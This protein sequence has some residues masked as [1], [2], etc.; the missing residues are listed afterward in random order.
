MHGKRLT[1]EELKRKAT[2]D[3]KAYAAQENA[4]KVIAGS[5][6]IMVG[7]DQIYFVRTDA[8]DIEVYLCTS[9]IDTCVGIALYGR[10]AAENM[11]CLTHIS[12]NQIPHLKSIIKEIHDKFYAVS[13]SKI[14]VYYHPTP[15]M[16]SS[17]KESTLSELGEQFRVRIELMPLIAPQ[18]EDVYLKLS[19]GQTGC[20]KAKPPGQMALARLMEGSSPRKTFADHVS[21]R[22]AHVSDFEG[23]FLVGDHTFEYIHRASGGGF[24][25]SPHPIS[26]DTARSIRK[27][28]DHRELLTLTAESMPEVVGTLRYEPRLP[29][30]IS[31]VRVR[32]EAY[33]I[34]DGRFILIP[35]RPAAVTPSLRAASPIRTHATTPVVSAQ[36]SLGLS[37]DHV[38]TETVAPIR[39]PSPIVTP[40]RGAARDLYRTVKTIS[41]TAHADLSVVGPSKPRE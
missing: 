20:Y 29:A 15:T 39:P 35:M 41:I 38:V 16:E 14:V 34:K 30:G 32:V 23:A 7:M 22:G 17:L 33:N 28:L 26:P 21:R 2:A 13:I 27:R 24:F 31:H 18:Y 11:G 36:K 1:L 6:T 40:P 9:G 25:S 37:S 4:G 5:K 12:G 3:R 8:T 10:T 19:D